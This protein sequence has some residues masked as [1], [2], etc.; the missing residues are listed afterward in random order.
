L[1]LSSADRRRGGQAPS[2]ASG[3]LFERR[4]QVMIDTQHRPDLAG[5]I[6]QRTQI[7]VADV[8]D[9]EPRALPKA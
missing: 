7:G 4:T 2:V 1:H 5:E 6:R 3:F 9:S 8:S